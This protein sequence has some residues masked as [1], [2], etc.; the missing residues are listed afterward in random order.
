MEHLRCT[1]TSKANYQCKMCSKN[2]GMFFLSIFNRL[3]PKLEIQKLHEL[4]KF[5]QEPFFIE[6]KRNLS[7]VPLAFPN[8]IFQTKINYFNN[9]N[10]KTLN[11]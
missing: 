2:K 9:N 1:L 10:P 6:K 5:L 11:T 7:K 3:E 8:S 4:P